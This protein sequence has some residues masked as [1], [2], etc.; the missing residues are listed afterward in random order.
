MLVRLVAIVAFG[1]AMALPA[2]PAQA[3]PGYTPSFSV[4]AY[5]RNVSDAAGGSERA[6]RD[7]VAKEKVAGRLIAKKDIPDDIWKLCYRVSAMNGGSYDLFNTCVDM[8]MGNKDAV[9]VPVGANG[10][11][12]NH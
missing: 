8:K 5:C 10:K 1:S 9:P 12:R 3:M 2:A 4:I 11:P 6:E 7:C